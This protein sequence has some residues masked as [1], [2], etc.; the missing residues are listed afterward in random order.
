VHQREITGDE[1]EASWDRW[2]PELV[3]ALHSPVIELI[4]RVHR[5]ACCIVAGL[6]L[7][8]DFP[9]RGITDTLSYSL[10]AERPAVEKAPGGER[11]AG[12]S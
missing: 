3:K 10:V 5:T 9:S 2:K 8:L 11:S 1:K 6:L 7:G 12:R 4:L